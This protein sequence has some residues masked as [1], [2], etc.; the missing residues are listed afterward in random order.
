VDERITENPRRLAVLNCLETR[1]RDILTGEKEE[2]DY[3]EILVPNTEFVPPEALGD[4]IALTLTYCD[5]ESDM[6]KMMEPI[7]GS[8][9]K[10]AA[11][12]RN[13]T[14]T[15]R[16]NLPDVPDE[17]VNHWL[18]TLASYLRSLSLPQYAQ[19]STG[20]VLSQPPGNSWV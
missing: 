5:C 20:K 11:T 17:W 7:K 19:S 13:A 10:I 18:N 15:F 1:W 4:E 12:V 6:A 8:L 2:I 9:R 16:R 3:T 14:S